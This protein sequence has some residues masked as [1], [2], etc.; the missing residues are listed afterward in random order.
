[1]RPH[2]TY[3][4]KVDIWCCLH[5]LFYTSSHQTDTRQGPNKIWIGECISMLHK[6][7]M[8]RVKTA[9]QFAIILIANKNKRMW[10]ETPNLCI[11]NP[12]VSHLGYQ[13]TLFRETSC[14]VAISKGRIS[15]AVF[16]EQKHTRRT[17]EAC[18]SSFSVYYPLIPFSFKF[19]THVSHSALL[20]QTQT[21]CI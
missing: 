18:L 6:Y 4:N 14:V 15:K 7:I 16:R 11:I 12:Q 3:A 21:Q 19:P 10:N 13:T 20:S 8:H 5:Y 17:G 2:F 9:V 1:M